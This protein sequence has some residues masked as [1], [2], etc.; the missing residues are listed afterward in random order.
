MPK[1]YTDPPLFSDGSST[2]RPS[3]HAK[4]YAGS[5]GSIGKRK[6]PSKYL[7]ESILAKQRNRCLYCGNAFG[8]GVRR[9]AK[10]ETVRLV[11]DHAAPFVYLQRNPSTNWVAA[12][13]ACNGIK[14]ALHFDTLVAAQEYIRERRRQKGYE[15]DAI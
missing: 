4:V 1:S 15:D 7:K 2:A 13:R 8:D 9:G 3:W 11:W 6:P 5:D 12:C 14:Y 10:T